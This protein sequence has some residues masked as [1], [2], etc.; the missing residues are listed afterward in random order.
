MVGMFENPNTVIFLSL[1]WG[2]GIAMLFR[3]IC[4]N[5]KCV[6]IKAPENLQNNDS[7]IF[8]KN[9]KCYI[10]KTYNTDCK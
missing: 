1:I 7:Q 10:L 8:K 3:K 4:H 6:I 9:N 2:I 5:G